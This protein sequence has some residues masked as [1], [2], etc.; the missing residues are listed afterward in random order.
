MTTQRR[1]APPGL[2]ALLDQLPD[3]ILVC[4]RGGKV[5][6]ANERV[7]ALLGYRASEIVGRPVEILLPESLRGMHERLREQYEAAPVTRPMGNRPDLAAL[8]RDGNWV[9]VDVSLAPGPGPDQVLVCLRDARVRIRHQRELAST[10]AELRIERDALDRLARELTESQSRTLAMFEAIPAGLVVLDSATR[11]LRM[12]RAGWH[13]LTGESGARE[14]ASRF[15]EHLCPEHRGRFVA[16]VAGVV[17]GRAETATVETVGGRVLELHATPFLFDGGASAYLAVATDVTEEAKLRRRVALAERMAS[18]GTLAAGLA[19]EINN[20]LTVVAG[21]LELLLAELVDSPE[22]RRWPEGL[23]M[24]REASEG[25]ARIARLV[26]DLRGMSRPGD[27]AVGPV[28]VNRVVQCAASLARNEIRARASLSV[29][30]G[31]VPAVRGNEAKLVQVVTNLLV[32]AAHAITEGRADRHRITVS[33]SVA[34]DQRVVISVTDDGCGIPDDVIPRIFD[35]FFTTKDVGQGTGLGLA[36][37]HDIVS[38][39]GG[40]MEVV[41]RVG[42]GSTFRVILGRSSGSRWPAVTSAPAPA[43]A[44]RRRLRV[45]VVDDERSVVAVVRR[46]LED[47]HDVEGFTEGRA[48]VARLAEDAAF[49][50]ILC[51]VMMPDLPADAVL[52]E[53]T[54]VA[55]S[56]VG[57]VV[58]MT[59]GAYTHRAKALV[60]SGR[61]PVLHKP[62]GVAEL[63]AAVAEAA[64]ARASEAPIARPSATLREL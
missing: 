23:E 48:A 7:F 35:P 41:S 51:D 40:E 55:P 19:H 58:L 15:V 62:L 1:D 38:Q 34:P 25:T 27:E 53:V 33:T 29:D 37:A 46:C 4:A 49:D 63:R 43:E 50:V 60:E 11:V 31:A 36:I 12:N 18:M 13:T 44:P 14:P 52:E 39:H 61:C 64:A 32:N 10:A 26:R 47:E 2:V 30:Y 28:D 57:R 45:L 6:H 5:I 54:R 42:L 56:L 20:P 16:H 3:A 24:L 17:G 59:G 21:N 8:D 22:G 9:P